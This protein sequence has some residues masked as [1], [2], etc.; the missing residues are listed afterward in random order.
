MQSPSDPLN[1]RVC[2]TQL[3]PGYRYCPNCGTAT[4][5]SAAASAD[6]PVEPDPSTMETRRFATQPPQAAPSP[7]TTTYSAQPPPPPADSAP[8]WGTPETTVAPE[9]GNR[10]LWI[11]L[12]IIAFIVL[13]CCCLLPLGMVVVANVDSEFQS[14]LRSIALIAGLQLSTRLDRHD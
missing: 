11:I 8:L 4:G 2:G 6:T 3:Q 9:S 5:L 14:E 12:G 10:T 7:E 13:V 1:C